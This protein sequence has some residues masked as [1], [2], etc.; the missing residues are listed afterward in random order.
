MTGTLVLTGCLDAIEHS[1][2]YSPAHFLT[3]S[4]FLRRL[5]A[6]FFLNFNILGLIVPVRFTFEGLESVRYLTYLYFL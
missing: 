1:A 4:Q 5:I 6:L 2:E 3:I